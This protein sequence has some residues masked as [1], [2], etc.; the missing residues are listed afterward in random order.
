MFAAVARFGGLALGNVQK[1]WPFTLGIDDAS[2]GECGLAMECS[3]VARIRHPERW[4]ET[5]ESIGG[6]RFSFR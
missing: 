6:P 5:P 4:Q 2:K 1:N 3:G